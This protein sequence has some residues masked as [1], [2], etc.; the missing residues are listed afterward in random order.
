MLCL[1]APQEV[2]GCG[3][4]QKRNAT[5]FNA[6]DHLSNVC[7]HATVATQS[8]SHTLAIIL[9]FLLQVVTGSLDEA[10][11]RD[12]ILGSVAIKY[13]QSNS[14]GQVRAT[15]HLCSYCIN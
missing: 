1:P 15:C 13:T 7:F 2:F 8:P 3:F 11:K 9:A 12:L 14:V 5:V 6:E 4:A 10:S